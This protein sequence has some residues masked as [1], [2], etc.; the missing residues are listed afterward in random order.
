MFNVLLVLLYK[1]GMCVSV[2]MFVV[3]RTGF[4]MQKTEV[5]LHQNLVFNGL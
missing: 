3:F 5:M 4:Y 2:R 1:V